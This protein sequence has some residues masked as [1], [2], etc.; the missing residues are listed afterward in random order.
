MSVGLDDEEFFEDLVFVDAVFMLAVQS[1]TSNVSV[2]VNG[3]YYDLESNGIVF[4]TTITVPFGLDYYYIVDG[5]S[6][7]N[8]SVKEYNFDYFK[9]SES[10]GSIGKGLTFGG[11][12]LTSHSLDEM[13]EKINFVKSFGFDRIAIIPEWFIFPD[14]NGVIIAPY[15]ES[16]S[17][18][19]S[20]NCFWHT[21]NDSN[22][23]QLTQYAKSQGLIVVYKPHIDGIDFCSNPLSSRGSTEPGNWSEWM[24]SYE[25]FILHYAAIA[26]EEGV[27]LFFVGTELDSAAHS[28]GKNPNAER[29]WRIIIDKVR[30][31]YNGS[32]AYSVSCFGDCYGPSA[33]EFWD[34]V[35]YISIEPYFGLTSVNNP[36]V[37]VMRLSFDNKLSSYAES[38]SE[39]YKKKVIF[40]EV[41]AYS[42]DGVNKDPING[43]LA[44]FGSVDHFEQAD[45]YEAFFKSISD[46][47]YVKSYY[48][49]AGYLD[50]M[51]QDYGNVLNDK[52][53][54]FMN[55]IAGQVVKKWQVE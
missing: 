8:H 9:K 11:M 1:N 3:S 43:E 55:K 35:D 54:P 53:D 36:S 50:T 17:F 52:Y 7:M 42:F 12:I 38:L 25:N 30:S 27:D 18:G 15:N 26:Q 31:V 44:A 39:E 47:D 24:N 41:N 14:Y 29:D 32:I 5:V 16:N 21:I 4:N 2:V 49:W 48:L 33:V 34:A 13:K 40:G 10:L 22:L 37:N 6:S 23:R 51:N 20:H 46:K 28:D 45:Y 19:Q